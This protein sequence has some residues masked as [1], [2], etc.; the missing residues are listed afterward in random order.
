MAEG[1]PVEGLDLLASL[2]EGALHHVFGEGAVATDQVRSPH[3]TDLVRPYK[4][5]E[6]AGVSPLGPLYRPSLVHPSL[7]GRLP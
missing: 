7:S 4:D 1:T 5:L 3:G 6:P 2:D